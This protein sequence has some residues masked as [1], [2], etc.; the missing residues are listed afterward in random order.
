[1]SIKN[2]THIYQ[3]AVRPILTYA[4]E[5]RADTRKTK[6]LLRSTEMRTLRSIVG[7]TLWNRRRSSDIKRECDEIPDIDGF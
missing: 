4:A 7:V 6:N 1:M 2:K 3:T 5:T